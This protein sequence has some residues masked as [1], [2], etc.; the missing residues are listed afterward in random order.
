MQYSYAISHR[1]KGF[2]E[3]FDWFTSD[4]YQEEKINSGEKNLP[5]LATLPIERINWEVDDNFSFF[6]VLF[7]TSIKSFF[8]LLLEFKYIIH[9]FFFSY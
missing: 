9:F 5:A 6:S 4:N 2:E 8:V 7:K 3:P 1:N